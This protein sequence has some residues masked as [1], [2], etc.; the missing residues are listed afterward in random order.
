MK[1]RR[2]TDEDLDYIVECIGALCRHTR[3]NAVSQL[4]LDLPSEPQP[5]DRDFAKRH[6]D[7]EG[8]FALI[9]VEGEERV[10]CALGSVQ[11]SGMSWSSRRVGHTSICWVE[12]SARR[13]G[14][15]RALLE[16]MEQL[17]TNFGVTVFELNYIATNE[18]AAAAWQELGYTPCRVL[19]TKEPS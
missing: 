8:S 5:K 7:T 9:A 3:A 1:V 13:R 2:A 4:V 17:F 19:A 15:A 11:D 18:E 14:V 6:L 16:R 12:E 10:G